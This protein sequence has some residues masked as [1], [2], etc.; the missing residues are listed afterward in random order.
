LPAGAVPRQLGAVWGDVS[1]D[2]LGDASADALGD[3]LADAL[4]ELLTA[5]P[6]ARGAR[7]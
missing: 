4:G 6:G 1:A 3:V 2:A 5:L 7:L